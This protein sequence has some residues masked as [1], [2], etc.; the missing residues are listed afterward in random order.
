M[1]VQSY[2]ISGKNTQETGNSGS[3]TIGE[4]G[5]WQ[6][7]WDTIFQCIPFHTSCIL[8]CAFIT[9]LKIRTF[10]IMS[11]L[12]KVIKTKGVIIIPNSS[13]AQYLKIIKIY[14]KD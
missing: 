4:L 2:S 1:F 5:N 13:V 9:Y 7:G 10:K 11:Y 14:D 8:Y 3:L 12:I 6:Q